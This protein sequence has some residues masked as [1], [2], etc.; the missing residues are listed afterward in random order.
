M[1]FNIKE[2][3][4]LTESSKS[5]VFQIKANTTMITNLKEDEFT[6]YYCLHEN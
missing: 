3:I 5:T 2:C 1:N 6:Q 4:L